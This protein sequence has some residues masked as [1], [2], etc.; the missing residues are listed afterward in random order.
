MFST[1]IYVS[2]LALNAGRPLQRE[3]PNLHRTFVLC[4]R[5][6][7]RLPHLLTFPYTSFSPPQHFPYPSLFFLAHL[8]LPFLLSYLFPLHLL[9]FFSLVPFPL[10]LFPYPP[11]FS[12]LLHFPF[13]PPPP[14]LF[15]HTPS[16]SFVMTVSGVCLSLSITAI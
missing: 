5:T 9:A 2:L 3:V 11:H 6:F 10:L 14:Y 7:S 8:P 4:N 1:L 15:P 13:P 12:P 16:P